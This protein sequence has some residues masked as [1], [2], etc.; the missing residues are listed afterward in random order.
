M[1]QVAHLAEALATIHDI[2]CGPQGE[3]PKMKK[4]GFHLDIQPRNILVFTNDV[5][6]DLLFEWTGFECSAVVEMAETA[7][8]KIPTVARAKRLFTM[9]MDP[10]DNELYQ[11]YLETSNEMYFPPESEDLSKP[12]TQAYDMWSMG[13]LMLDLLIWGLYGGE[14]L[15]IDKV[16]GEM[17]STCHRGV[18]E[19]GK[20]GRSSQEQATGVGEKQK[21]DKNR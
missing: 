17:V 3:G 21:K 12:V 5:G 7:E 2:P 9:D 20:R 14:N 6:E 13:V 10:A 8:S 1:A 15:R 18:E 16:F 19:M 4:K 11:K